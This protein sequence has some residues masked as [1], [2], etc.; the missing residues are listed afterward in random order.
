MKFKDEKRV[1][2]SFA[3]RKA[4]RFFY[5]QKFFNKFMNLF[6]VEGLTYQQFHYIMKK[7]WGDGT[8]SCSLPVGLPKGLDM[9]E[10]RVIFTPWAPANLYN[11]YDY[12][13]SA[14]PINTRGVTFISKEPLTIDEGIVIGYI[15]KN[16]KSLFSSIEAKLGQLVDYEMIIRT[17][18]KSQKLPF[19]FASSP[20]NKNAIDQLIDS[21]NGDD[22]TIVTL[23]ENVAETKLFPTTPSFNLDKLEQ[24]RQK[25][26]NDILTILGV[27]NVGI[28]EKKEHLVVDEINA[29]NQDIDSNA[30]AYL[31]ELKDFFGRINEIFGTNFNV[32][33]K[34]EYEVEEVE[35]ED[36]DD[37]EI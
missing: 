8:I 27:N 31:S 15:Q 9:G 28:A 29:N 20:E 12:P 21:Y 6:E 23:L 4:F 35:E 10:N 32:R 1:V 37:S 17:N 7:F 18:L 2:K 13:I 5:E 22:D 11:I 33:L 24:L 34:N 30:K 3:V 19:I 25:L 36:N 26:E 16:H 14:L